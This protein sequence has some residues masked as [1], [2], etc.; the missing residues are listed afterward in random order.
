MLALR[1]AQGEDG[2][3][4]DAGRPRLV[5]VKG[6]GSLDQGEARNSYPLARWSQGGPGT[7]G[8]PGLAALTIWP[9][10]SACAG[11]TPLS[12]FRPRKG[13]MGKE[14]SAVGSWAR[15]PCRALC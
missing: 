11:T 7:R 10:P 15:A 5:H 4:V 3:E 8:R 14:D 2:D 6:D 1:G 12:F 9:V 13:L